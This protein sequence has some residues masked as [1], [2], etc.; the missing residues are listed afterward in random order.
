MKEYLND[1]TQ[2]DH[3]ITR[4][5]FSIAWRILG[6][7]A[8]WFLGRFIIRG[9]QKVLSSGLKKRSVD[10]TLIYYANSTLGLFLKVLLFLVIFGLFGV[11]TTSFSALLAA[12][13]VAIGVGWSG[14]LANFAAGIFLILLRPFKVGDTI[15]A[16]GVT[17]VVREIGLFATAIDNGENLRVFVSNNKLF[18]DNI[19]NYSLNDYRMALFK[20]QLAHGVDPLQA[21]NLLAS[22]LQTLEPISPLPKVAGD[23]VEFNTLGTIVTLRVP[24]HHSQYSAAVAGGNRLIYEAL[25]IANFPLPLPR[26]FLISEA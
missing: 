10:P 12:A 22:A 7:F 15:S 23:I 21:I 11:E 8:I 16:A 3:L 25:K 20:V 26:T 17:G 14:L 19:L 4:F 6:A 5:F 13:G 18:S 24:C 2:V 9:A 1:L